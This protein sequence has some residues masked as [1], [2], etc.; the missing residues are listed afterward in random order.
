MVTI[1]KYLL[2]G[3][4]KFNYIQTRD[5]QVSSLLKNSNNIENYINKEDKNLIGLT[6]KEWLITNKPTK[7]YLNSAESK[8]FIERI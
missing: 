6:F 3:S 5:Y 4:N 1:Q 2:D 7:V 8:K